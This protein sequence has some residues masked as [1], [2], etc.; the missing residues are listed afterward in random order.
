MVG[1]PLTPREETIL[2]GINT[3][4]TNKQIGQALGISPITVS[5][6]RAAAARKLG[7]RNRIE[8]VK[9]AEQRE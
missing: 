1:M 8:L 6:H 3:G 7:A 5:H 4:A 2:A 9:A